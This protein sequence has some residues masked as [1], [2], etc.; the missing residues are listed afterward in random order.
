M[1]DN[2]LSRIYNKSKNRLRDA[3]R[4]CVG[5]Y[6]R[7]QENYPNAKKFSKAF[8]D[9]MEKIVPSNDDFKDKAKMIEWAKSVA[10]NS[11]IGKRK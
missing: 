3:C 11:M 7:L 2:E 6:E 4:G 8:T 10:L 1:A 5:D 9:N